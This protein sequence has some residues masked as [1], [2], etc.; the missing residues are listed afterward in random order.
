LKESIAMLARD[1]MT[2]NVVTVR[3]ETP[4]KE[5]AGT[6]LDRRIS[7][8][9]VVDGK[10]VIV[11]IVSE[12]DLMRRP[13]SGGEGHRSWWLAF[14]SLPEDDARR[15]VKAH[16]RFAS[17][18]MTRKVV[19]VAENEPLEEV[20]SVLERARIKRVPV[21]QDGKLVGIISR[22]DLLRGIASAK[23][24][25]TPSVGD[26]T[27][28]QAV[29]AALR[30]HPGYG[31]EFV[32]VTVQDGVAHLW[33]GVEQQAEKDAARVATEN[34]PGVREVKDMISIFPPDVRNVLWAE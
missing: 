22:A 12:G 17:D 32:T 28:Q 34:V 3:P 1:V 14:F 26:R 25:K 5:I 2:K 16:G 11:G 21:V 23:I 18:V 15:F 7:A 6:L 30:K 33:G 31:M 9:P 29:E 20:A 24:A 8:V 13:E 10:G 4:V 19:T 27:L